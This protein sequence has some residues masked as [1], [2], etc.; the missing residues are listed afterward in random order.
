[1]VQVEQGSL[2]VVILSSGRTRAT[3]TGVK[4][5]PLA[6][7]CYVFS[8]PEG[9]ALYVGK[10]I[11]LRDRLASYFAKSRERKTAAMVGHAKTVEWHTVG[12]EVEALILES[13]LVKRFQPPYNVQLRE[14]PHY[15][16]LRRANG[17]GFA[18]YEL[19]GSVEPE[20]GAHYGPFW[21]RR[22]AE[23]T[24][25]F[26]NRLFLLRRCE[27]NL[28]TAKEGGACFYAQVRRCSAPCLGRLSPEEYASSVESAGE[29]LRGDVGQLIRRLERD[30]DTAAEAL[31]FE[32]AAELHQAIT[33]LKSLQSK[34]RHLRSAAH[35]NNFLV[36][37]QQSNRADAQV[38]AFSAARLRGQ[39][40]VDAM[41]HD[42]AQRSALQRFVLEHYPV[43]RELAIDLD[44][45][46]QMHVVAEWLARQGRH[47]VYVPL[48]D[49]PLS[50]RDAERAVDSVVQALSGGLGAPA[51][52]DVTSAAGAAHFSQ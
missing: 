8:D 42:P 23:Q 44:E 28:P 39:L 48:P 47:A 1:M 46:D 26:V 49:G 41:L 24:L 20:A 29:L 12:S 16:F 11:A 22:S 51:R 38:L 50:A 45:L 25:E 3:R 30:R 17:G 9:A 43:R 33:T 19:A 4:K 40:D 10:S 15:K 36:V 13:Q 31:R 21:G 34:R 7:G 5:A 2:P 37:V 6:P 52:M 14:Y 32:R 35:T 18:Y 27:G